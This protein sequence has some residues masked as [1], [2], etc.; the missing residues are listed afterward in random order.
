MIE[1]IRDMFE[2]RISGI[3][4]MSLLDF[5]SMVSCILF[6]NGCRVCHC[7]YCYNKGMWNGHGETMDGKK[8]ERFLKSRVGKIDGVVFSGGEC[9]TWGDDLVND[10]KW[11]RELGYKVKLDTNGTNPSL[12]NRMLEER[13]VDYVAMDVKCPKE[14]SDLFYASGQMYDNFLQSLDVLMAYEREFELRTTVHPDLI[15]EDDVNEITAMLE[16][17]GYEGKYYLQFFFDDGRTEYLDN[18]I[19]REPR[20]FDVGKLEKRKNISVELR[21]FE[22]RVV[23]EVEP[24]A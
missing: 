1:Y 15:D 5:P 7:P 17:F 2:N 21:N 12:L 18:S 20:L 8:V 3:E 9:T 16:R 10:I 19:N 13:L 6:Y 14:K 24:R 11:T 4:K 22:G 23:P